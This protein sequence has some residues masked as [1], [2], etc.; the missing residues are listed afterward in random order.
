MGY[1]GCLGSKKL[2]QRNDIFY[3]YLYNYVSM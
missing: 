2:W 1:I 3:D